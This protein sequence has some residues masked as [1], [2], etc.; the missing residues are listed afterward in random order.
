MRLQAYPCNCTDN[1]NITPSIAPSFV[2]CMRSHQHNMDICL[3]KPTMTFSM[4]DCAVW[5]CA[6]VHK[7]DLSCA[8]LITVLYF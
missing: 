8:P 2:N 1:P 4:Q 6:W 5:A 3:P 7:Q